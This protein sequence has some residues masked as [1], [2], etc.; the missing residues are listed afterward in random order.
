M[1][2]KVGEKVYLL[3]KR[4]EETKAIIKG[5]IKSRTGDTFEVKHLDVIEYDKTYEEL[6]SNPQNFLINSYNGKERTVCSIFD[7]KE[8]WLYRWELPLFS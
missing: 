4:E 3:L 5:E 1:V 7:H 8:S 2:I 6:F